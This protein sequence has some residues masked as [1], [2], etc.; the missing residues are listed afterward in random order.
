MV[1]VI[2][3]KFK[4]VADQHGGTSDHPPLEGPP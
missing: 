4:S 3:N 2:V 1:P